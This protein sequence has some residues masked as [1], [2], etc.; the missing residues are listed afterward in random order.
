[1][2]R[3][4]KKLWRRRQIDGGRRHRARPRFG[5]TPGIVQKP[6]NYP[7]RPYHSALR[8]ICVMSLLLIW[9]SLLCQGMGG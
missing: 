6:L 8:G 9:R 2:G 5:T 1:M 7:A 3:G 4:A